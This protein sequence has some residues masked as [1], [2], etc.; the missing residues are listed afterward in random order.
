MS[1]AYSNARERD[2]RPSNSTLPIA[3][4]PSYFGFANVN[5]LCILQNAT[6]KAYMPIEHWSVGI[7]HHSFY[8]LCSINFGCVCVCVWS[9]LICGRLDSKR[10]CV[11]G[12]VCV[13]VCMLKICMQC[14]A[15]TNTFV[16][17]SC[18]AANYIN[19]F[20]RFRTAIDIISI[21][22]AA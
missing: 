21:V 18:I 4:I 15:R 14:N 16:C 20:I 3:V 19:L 10:A 5:E 2:A 9:D 1:T 13:C 7:R 17:S 11:S 6:P 22:I 12:S 8:N